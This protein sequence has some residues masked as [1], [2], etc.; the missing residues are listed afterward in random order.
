MQFVS[1]V[2]MLGFVV[3]CNRADSRFESPNRATNVAMPPA[4]F[5]P[6]SDAPEMQLYLTPDGTG[7]FTRGLSFL[8]PVRWSYN[9]A[10]HELSLKFS[11]MSA[12]TRAVLKDGV[13]RG[14]AARFE[15]R[16]STLVLKVG[17]ETDRIWVAGWYFFRDSQ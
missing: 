4:W 10:I 9:P 1:S 17:P 13:S 7:H 6:P 2:L 5:H 11:E 15:E 16:D 8:N 14:Y 3:G 12:S